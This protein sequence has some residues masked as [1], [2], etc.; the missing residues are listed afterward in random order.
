MSRPFQCPHWVTR[1]VRAKFGRSAIPPKTDI[2]SGLCRMQIFCQSL[3]W[4]RPQVESDGKDRVD[5]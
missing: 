5:E 1:L 3:H 4:R 2:A